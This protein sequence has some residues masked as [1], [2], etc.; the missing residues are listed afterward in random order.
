MTPYAPVGSAN[1][2]LVIKHAIPFAYSDGPVQCLRPQR[3]DAQRW[4]YRLPH[5]RRGPGKTFVMT[6]NVGGLLFDGADTPPT[7]VTGGE[8]PTAPPGSTSTKCFTSG[9]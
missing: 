9:R 3:P 2:V 1:D 7:I 8:M 4:C 5:H 6:S